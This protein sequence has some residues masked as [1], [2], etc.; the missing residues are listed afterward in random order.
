MSVS[1][2]HIPSRLKPCEFCWSEEELKRRLKIPDGTKYADD[3]GHSIMC[4]Y[5]LI[6]RKSN[7]DI[8]KAIVQLENTFRVIKEQKLTLKEVI[9]LCHRLDKNSTGMYEAKTNLKVKRGKYVQKVLYDKKKNIPIY[10]LKDEN[11]PILVEYVK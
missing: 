5:F 7:A 3:Y 8:T 6:E 2:T 9:I 1:P 10:C 4:T 11:Y